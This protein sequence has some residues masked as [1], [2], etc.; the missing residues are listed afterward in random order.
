MIDVNE[1][2]AE[3]FQKRPECDADGVFHY[4]L[5]ERNAAEESRRSNGG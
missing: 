5:Q 4:I 3:L 1:I 2:L